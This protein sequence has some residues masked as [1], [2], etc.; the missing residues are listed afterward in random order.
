MIP[1]PTF[2]VVMDRLDER[3]HQKKLKDLREKAR[4]TEQQINRLTTRARS[5]Q[6]QYQVAFFAI[7]AVKKLDDEFLK[8]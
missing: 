2:L 8:V 5:G 3:R 1:V 6:A 4:K 7:A